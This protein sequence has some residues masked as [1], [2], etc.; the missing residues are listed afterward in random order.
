MKKKT[1]I[2]GGYRGIG[3]SIYETIKK[4]GDIVF[5][6]CRSK[7]KKKN[8]ISADITK[9]EGINLIKNFFKKE[10]ID[11]LI[12][13]QRYR[14]NDSEEEYNVILK[15]TNNL[16]KISKFK[17]KNSSIVIL[18]S[19][20]STTIIG[21][22]NETYHFTRGALET[23]TKYY[24]YKLGKQNIRVNCIQPTKIF[25]PENKKFFS[26]KNN[27]DR[28]LIEKITPI[29]RMGNSTDIANLAE[30]LTSEKSSYITGVIIP[31]DGGL[32][33][34]G[35]EQIAKMFKK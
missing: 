32:R 4:R 27:R 18:G 5:C 15:A 3:K 10:K 24:A 13:T 1:L 28:K 31:V 2:I 19:I 21:D 29:G 16:I 35:Q 14:G 22:Q 26:K 17:N 6:I 25:K 8:F 11:N 33:L 7:I 20:A 30:F 34:V 23:L 9:K 12:F